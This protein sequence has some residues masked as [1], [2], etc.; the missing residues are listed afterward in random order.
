MSPALRF[1]PWPGLEAGVV[2]GGREGRRREARGSRRGATEQTSQR[3]G[4]GSRSD[5]LVRLLRE[6]HKGAVERLVLHL[7]EGRPD[8]RR[9]CFGFLRDA[10]LGVDG[11]GA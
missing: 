6:A 7:A 9:R 2:A 4:A 10:M 11:K 8:V 5:R 3:R 1:F